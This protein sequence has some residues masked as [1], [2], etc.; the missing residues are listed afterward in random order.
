MEEQLIRINQMVQGGDTERIVEAIKETNCLT[1]A[2]ALG[3]F[4]VIR[5][6][7]KQPPELDRDAIESE[8]AATNRPG[9]NE[10]QVAKE[11]WAYLQNPSKVTEQQFDIIGAMLLALID[12]KAAPRLRE[13]GRIQIAGL[14]VLM[15]MDSQLT[16]WRTLEHGLYDWRG[17]HRSDVEELLQLLPFLNP[18]IEKYRRK[19]VFAYP[20]SVVS[21]MVASTRAGTAPFGFFLATLMVVVAAS[22]VGWASQSQ[23]VAD[24]R[25]ET[26]NEAAAPASDDS[27][28][29]PQTLAR[30]LREHLDSKAANEQ[31]QD[32]AIVVLPNLM[33]PDVVEGLSAAG[34]G[35]VFAVDDE[36]GACPHGCEWLSRD[37]L[38]QLSC[39]IIRSRQESGLQQAMGRIQ[40]KLSLIGLSEILIGRGI[41]AGAGGHVAL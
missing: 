15:G 14:A 35:P 27:N 38:Q 26:S 12:R 22:L 2:L 11:L 31:L 40:G 25:M 29:E 24:G 10:Q 21:G 32:A 3:F 13:H 20:I 33:T 28:D 7:M 36:F 34:I 5:L 30:L 23:G 9:L 19:S 1:E 39:L 41:M 16:V 6:R 8:I 18:R 4:G 17:E 37:D